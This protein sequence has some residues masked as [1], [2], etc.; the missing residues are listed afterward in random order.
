MLLNTTEEIFMRNVKFP[1][2]MSTI[3]M[4]HVGLIAFAG[5]ISCSKS[6]KPTRT[7]AETVKQGI[8]QETPMPL[9]PPRIQALKDSVS[10][11]GELILCDLSGSYLSGCR[12]DEKELA[13]KADTRSEFKIRYVFNCP[14]DKLLISISTDDSEK[15]LNVKADTD[16]PDEILI[17]GVGPLNLRNVDPEHNRTAILSKSCRFEVISVEINRI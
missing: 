10:A 11:Q 3:L 6:L 7:G 9:A 8:P 14:G 17:Q 13:S 5:L 4:F 15:L 16:E 1:V 12:I 2:L